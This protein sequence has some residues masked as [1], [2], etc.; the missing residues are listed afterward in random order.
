MA[1]PLRLADCS[2]IT[3]EMERA[4]VDIIEQFGDE[5]SA[6]TLVSLVFQAMERA[7]ILG[8]SQRHEKT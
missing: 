8:A 4:G 3:P 5:V 6:A 7:R 2:D 1:E